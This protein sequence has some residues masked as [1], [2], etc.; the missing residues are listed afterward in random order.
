MRASGVIAKL[1]RILTGVAAAAGLTV[2][3]FFAAVPVNAA[4]STVEVSTSYPGI[5]T[6][7]GQTVSFDLDFNNTG[8][9]TS[10]ELSSSGLPSGWT[11]EFDGN[12]SKISAVY[13]KAGENDSLA[14]YK[15]D[16][17]DDAKNGDYDI[18]I[19]ANSSS[20]KLTINVTDE[21]TGDSGLTTD[22]TE[23]EGPTGTTFTYSLTLTNNSATEQTY[24]LNARK[25]E[26][27]SVT[28][29]PSDGSND[30]AS[31]NVDAHASTTLTAT[32]TPPDKVSAGDYEIPVTAISADQSLSATLKCKIT[33]TYSL[34][35]TTSDQTLS[36]NANAGHEKDVTIT[37]TN[38]G[39]IDLNAV[40][41]SVTAPDGWDASFDTT[42][43]DTIAAGESQTVTLKTTPAKNAVS[44][45]YTMT[46]S[47]SND[48]ASQ[49]ATFRVTVKTGTAW[50]IAGVVIIV[51]VIAGL[52]AIF[53]KF[54]RH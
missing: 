4:G 30:V 47:A 17:P 8:S 19:H 34:D 5:S 33:G 52:M 14:T 21:E 42:T 20:L 2:S 23:Q 9:G 13:A 27:W 11:D 16:V 12:G 7:P 36:F 15:V 39:N 46:V 51:V 37:V 32:V 50:G 44:G 35:V 48:N 18:S 29:K 6:K 49:D 38:T 25:A 40:K 43:I 3:S 41:L 28:F 31:I 54:G 45:D 22:D 1:G 53:Q 24:A 10:V 26:G